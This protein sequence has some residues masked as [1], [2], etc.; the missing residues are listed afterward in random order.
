MKPFLWLI[1]LAFVA[2]LSIFAGAYLLEKEGYVLVSYGQHYVEATLFGF[3]L[4]LVLL[5]ASIR[6]LIA[7]I[8]RIFSLKAST[9]SFFSGKRTRQ[10]NAAFQQGLNAFLM[11]DWA[12]AEKLF[13]AAG[14]KG[15]LVESRQLYAA[16]AADAMGEEEKAFEHLAAL[17]TSDSTADTDVALIKAQ[18]LLK[19][20]EPEEAALIIKPLYKQSPKNE[21]VF[22]SYLKVLQALKDWPELLALYSKVEKSAI[23]TEQQFNEWYLMVLKNALVSSIQKDTLSGAEALWK[24]LPGKIKKRADVLAIYIGV[25]DSHGGTEQ[26]E[27]LLLKSLKKNPIADFLPLFRQQCFSHSTVM[28]SYLQQQLK[29]DENNPELLCALGYLAAASDDYILASKALAKVVQTHPQ[30]VDL[31]LLAD[32]YTRAGDTNN[33]LATYQL[34]RG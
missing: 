15:E 11:Q 24:G 16:V 7:I 28:S 6:L 9:S 17:T 8:K 34:L 10:A 31:W 2:C 19:Q 18:L 29:A 3:I 20:Q 30:Q 1:L 4:A 23:L 32:V 12:R 5:W 21:A 27:T 26:A 22:S 13:V 25:L 14:N 33:A